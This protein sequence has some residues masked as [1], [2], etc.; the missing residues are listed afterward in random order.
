M[1]TVNGNQELI[2]TIVALSNN[3]FRAFR[4]ASLD[5]KVR[6]LGQVIEEA[7]GRIGQE[8]TTAK[9]QLASEINRLMRA[10]KAELRHP[11]TSRP[12]ILLAI[13]DK[14]GGKFVYSDKET[15]QR[16][17]TTKDIRKMLPFNV[18]LT[19]AQVFIWEVPARNGTQSATPL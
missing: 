9:Q 19:D 7:V 5:K 4:R 15:K 6:Q 2:A 13:N 3:I 11:E 1:E 10:A 17:G 12:C 16:S 18:A 14:Y 8:G